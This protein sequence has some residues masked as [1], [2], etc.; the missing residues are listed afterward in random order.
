MQLA[1]RFCLKF[2][3]T[4]YALERSDVGMFESEM[5]LQR[6]KGCEGLFAARL[7]TIN[8]IFASVLGRLM[9]LK[10]ILSAKCFLAVAA[11]MRS[12]SC[13]RHY[14]PFELSLFTEASAT[15]CAHKWLGSIIL[16][17]FHVL[18]QAFFAGIKFLADAA[19]MLVTFACSRNVSALKGS[20]TD[21]VHCL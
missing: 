12:F 15:A 14:M 8:H 6:R 2:L 11:G 3:V 21:C 16:V 17:S 19:W 10:F 7:L 4:K 13:M 18:T 20:L 9:I 5:F 1:L